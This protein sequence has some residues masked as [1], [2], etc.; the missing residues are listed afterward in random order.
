MR[1][2]GQMAASVVDFTVHNVVGSASLGFSVDLPRCYAEH[3]ARIVVSRVCQ[4]Q[5]CFRTFAT[6]IPQISLAYSIDSGSSDVSSE[7]RCNEPLSIP[8]QP[9]C[10]CVCVCLIRQQLAN[11]QESIDD[12]DAPTISFT[13]FTSGKMVLTG[14][15]RFEDLANAFDAT[16]DLLFSYRIPTHSNS[17]QTT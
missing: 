7:Q 3:Q 1:D 4:L 11:G 9:Q 6:T 5:M 8:I 12:I 15:R 2:L 13:I 16:K 10:V 14:A 17:V